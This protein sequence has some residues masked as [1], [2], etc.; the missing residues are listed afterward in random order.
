MAADRAIYID[1]SQS[2]NIHMASPTLPTLTSC[3]RYAWESGLKTG[4]YYLRTKPAS[5]P[6][7]FTVDKAKFEIAAKRHS[8]NLPQ[9]ANDVCLLGSTNGG[10]SSF[11]NNNLTDCEMCS[12]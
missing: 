9:P 6:I 5:N 12:A 4:M 8:C 10:G 7:A 1:Q 2:F 3:H 11:C